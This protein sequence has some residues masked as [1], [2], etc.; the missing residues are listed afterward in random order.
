MARVIDRS[1]PHEE[2]RN[3]AAY[4]PY[5]SLLPGRYRVSYRLKLDAPSS[6]QGP[7]ATVDVFSTA[8]GGS[9]AGEDILV[10]DFVAPG[11]YQDFSVD[12]EIPSALE[13]VEYRVLFDGPE[14]LWLDAVE[15]APLQAIIPIATYK[16]EQMPGAAA[17]LIP[18]KYQAVVALRLLK[19]GL[20]GRV[21]TIEVFSETAGGPLATLDVDASAFDRPD[22]SRDFT[23]DFETDQPWPDIEFRVLPRDGDSVRADRVQ[24]SYLVE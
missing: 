2:G 4:G 5:A 6:R 1:L 16:A 3:A 8:M 22:A 23:L 20:T 9:L 12:V 11:Q 19:E 18:G 10:Q 24:L 7:V 14:R 21:A 15:V 17:R 13:D